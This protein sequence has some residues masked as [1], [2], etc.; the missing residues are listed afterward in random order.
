MAR[1]RSWK[2]WAKH[3]YRPSRASV[4]RNIEEARK[5]C[6][7]IDAKRHEALAGHPEEYREAVIHAALTLWS[8][9]DSL[10]LADGFKP[11]PGEPWESEGAIRSY[12]YYKAESE[13]EY[14]SYLSEKEQ[15]SQR[16]G[17]HSDAVAEH[18]RA[19]YAVG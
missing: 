19:V 7:A 17:I 10:S 8:A 5:S 9:R 13:K 2:P 11:N 3:S 12:K 6:E 15:I 18:I 4:K 1:A 14:E 16:F